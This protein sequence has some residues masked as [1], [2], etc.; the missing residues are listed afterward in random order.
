M[1][2]PPLQ[3]DVCPSG[4][5]PGTTTV[6]DLAAWWLDQQRHRVRPSSLGKYADR[7]DGFSAVLGQELVS[8]LT[9]GAGG[10][11]VAA[12]K[13][14]GVLGAPVLAEAVSRWPPISAWPSSHVGGAGVCWPPIRTTGR[15]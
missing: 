11:A 15:A 4:S 10:V 3:R 14:H 13:G 9:G 12:P 6:S 1:T 2:R 7:I 5:R 8:E